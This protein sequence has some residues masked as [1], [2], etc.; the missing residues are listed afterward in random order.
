MYATLTPITSPSAFTS[1]PPELPGEIGA[2]VW[3]RSTSPGVFPPDGIE[4][5]SPE[6][7]PAVTVFSNPSGLPIA[8]ATSPTCGIRSKVSPAGA[9]AAVVATIED[10]GAVTVFV[11]VRVGPQPATTAHA[12]RTASADSLPTRKDLPSSPEAETGRLGGGR[13]R[14][15]A[16]L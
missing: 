15:Q 16:P 9:C 11:T 1:A 3:I 7:I 14:D 6:T 13:R 5:C 8:I 2:S 4:R 10:A 12:T